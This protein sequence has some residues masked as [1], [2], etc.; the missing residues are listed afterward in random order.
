[1]TPSPE[2]MRIAV[3][4]ADKLCDKPLTYEEII[5]IIAQ[6]F[7]AKDDAAKA[8]PTTALQRNLKH[9]AMEQLIEDEVQK[10]WKKEKPTEAAQQIRARLSNAFDSSKSKDRWLSDYAP[11]YV[12]DLVDIAAQ[13]GIEAEIK[14][15]QD[16]VAAPQTVNTVQARLE[17]LEDV[18]K[19]LTN[20]FYISNLKDAVERVRSLIEGEKT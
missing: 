3:Q 1:M 16:A 13:W 4:L 15:L 20:D 9:E 10:L 12:W 14:K 18:V 6:A 2:N 8:E 19:E 7:E 11:D 17:A 5:Q